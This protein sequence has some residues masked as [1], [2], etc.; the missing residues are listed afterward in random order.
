[1]SLAGGTLELSSGD[2][3]TLLRASLPLGGAVGVQ[4][5]PA[6]ATSGG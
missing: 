6:V 1:V 4:A 3:G 2:H 5:A